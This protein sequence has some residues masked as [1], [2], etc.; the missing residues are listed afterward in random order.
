MDNTLPDH[1]NAAQMSLEQARGLLDVVMGERNPE[2]LARHNPTEIM[3]LLWAVES[4]I[5]AADTSTS[6]AFQVACDERGAFARGV[7]QGL[8][9][10]SKARPNA[11]N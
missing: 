6:K 2:D 1:L 5:D 3:A 10:A 7:V 9:N 11:P 4:A 8:L